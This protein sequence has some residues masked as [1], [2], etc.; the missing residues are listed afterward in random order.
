MSDNCRGT[1]LRWSWI[2]RLFTS[3][4]CSKR[5][6][7]GEATSRVTENRGHYLVVDD[8]SG[9]KQPNATAERSAECLA[10]STGRP[11]TGNVA[12][13]GARRLLANPYLLPSPDEFIPGSAKTVLKSGA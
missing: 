10:T 5:R 3:E 13:T 8:D 1:R 6:L 11:F 7:H 9:R 12:V 2:G 4:P